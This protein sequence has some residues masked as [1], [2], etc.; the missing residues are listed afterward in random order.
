MDNSLPE[1]KER[2]QPL[3]PAHIDLR[4]FPD[5]PLDVLALRGSDLTDF[6]RGDEFRAAVL[7]WCAAW[8]E[9]PAGSLPN[10]P[11][12][13]GVLS[14]VGIGPTAGQ[15]FELV[16]EGAL[17]GFIECSD[18]RLY[19]PVVCARALQAWERKIEFEAKN[20]A[21]SEGGRAGAKKRWA[22]VKAQ[23][24]EKQAA[25]PIEPT[26]DASEQAN[27][28][29]NR[30]ATK[31]A[32]DAP[33]Y[34]P[35]AP[36]PGNAY[37]LMLSRG[38]TLTQ[39]AVPVIP[40]QMA[41]HALFDPENHRGAIESD[42]GAIE[43]G[44]GVGN[45]TLMRKQ[46]VNVNLV[47]LCSNAAA[48]EQGEGVGNSGKKTAK[49]TK[50]EIDGW[51][52]EWWAVVPRKDAKLRARKEYERAL[53]VARTESPEIE[54]HVALLDGMKRYAKA[55][56][57]VERSKIKM[58]DGWLSTGRW[59]DDDAALGTGVPHDWWLTWPGV[60]AQGAKLK[61]EQVEGESK[62]DYKLRVLIK[63][64]AGPWQQAALDRAQRENSH[65]L[66]ARLYEHFH[67]EPPPG[68][69]RR[70]APAIPIPPAPGRGVT[71]TS[72][73]REYSPAGSEAMALIKQATRRMTVK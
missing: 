27:G 60:E 25:L 63:S 5:M 38:F 45:D 39:G 12:K 58:P 65:E 30:E 70:A 57:G 50:P 3:V 1:G 66:Y 49:F 64:G 54:P 19:H 17:H 11:Q 62:A 22:K 29:A 23:A 10:D 71:P 53:Y 43:G 6:R 16:R 14:K 72:T 68:S 28:E 55:C 7:L 8:H 46:R 31:K 26:G 48:S 34:G 9:V 44:N 36:Q 37:A 42:R 59:L 40:T 67:G 13:L 69:T 24:A 20:A 18:G 51:F 33:L 47:N 32:H 2:P 35:S 61:L 73:A 52:D 15:A 56:E 4:N 21:M 41:Q